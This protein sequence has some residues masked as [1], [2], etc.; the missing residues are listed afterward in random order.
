[1]SATLTL[2]YVRLAALTEPLHD[3]ANFYVIVCLSNYSVRS[4]YISR[5]PI[6]CSLHLAG[7]LAV[8]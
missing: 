2:A 5:T 1:M 8:S 6:N 4:S 3:I 7:Y